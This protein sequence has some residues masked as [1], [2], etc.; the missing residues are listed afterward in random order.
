M[1]DQPPQRI[2]ESFSAANKELIY[3]HISTVEDHSKK[4]QTDFTII[5]RDVIFA[6]LDKRDQSY[7]N[8]ESESGIDFVLQNYKQSFALKKLGDDK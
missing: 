3:K 8:S 1:D 6:V 7:K 5:L 4:M 2:K